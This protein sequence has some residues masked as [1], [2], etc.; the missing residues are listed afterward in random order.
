MKGDIYGRHLW[1]TSIIS[2]KIE[3]FGGRPPVGGMVEGLTPPPKSGPGQKN[4]L[5]RSGHVE[6]AA[7]LATKIGLAIRL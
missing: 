6:Q 7:A 1:E 3:G 2:Q 5:M 4:K